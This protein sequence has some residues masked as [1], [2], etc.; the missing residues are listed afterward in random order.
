MILSIRSNEDAG[1]VCPRCM[2]KNWSGTNC[3]R[4]GSPD[5]TPGANYPYRGG[6][7]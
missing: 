1:Y 7:S 2:Q 3:T 5:P 4:C 6:R